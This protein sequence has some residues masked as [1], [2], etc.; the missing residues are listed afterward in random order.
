MKPSAV[1]I[2]CLISPQQHS[3]TNNLAFTEKKGFSVQEEE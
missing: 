3:E 1:T 2:L